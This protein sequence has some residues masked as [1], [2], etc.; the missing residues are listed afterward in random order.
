MNYDTMI[1]VKAAVSVNI[2][3]LTGFECK[4]SSQGRPLLSYISLY[5]SLENE[6]PAK[7]LHHYFLNGCVLA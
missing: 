5:L 2:G 6:K 4:K 1:A 3:K 7:I